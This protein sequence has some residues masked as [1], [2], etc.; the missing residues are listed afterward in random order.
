MN[1]SSGEAA[2]R[3]GMSPPMQNEPGNEQRRHTANHNRP[4]SR[5]R[6]I[7]A[8]GF[9]TDEESFENRPDYRFLE[10]SRSVCHTKM[11]DS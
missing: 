10:S 11:C 6:P 8:A 1:R 9:S 4:R 7:A 5:I 2:T 3:S